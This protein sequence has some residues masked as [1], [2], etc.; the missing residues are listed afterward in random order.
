M[1][2]RYSSSRRLTILSFLCVTLL[3]T[4][5]L[6]AE[7]ATSTPMS[8]KAAAE[9]ANIMKLY[10]QRKFGSAAFRC[11]RAIPAA[12]NR[13]D[14]LPVEIIK[15]CAQANLKLGD[16][17]A[18]V[19]SYRQAVQRWRKAGRLDVTLYDDEAFSR[20]LETGLPGSA[21]GARR[22]D[23]RQ[24][25]PARDSFPPKRRVTRIRRQ[26]PKARKVAPPK[27]EWPEGEKGP[28]AG[29]V[30]GVGVSGG[31]D[32][33]L[34]V[35]LAWMHAERV[36]VEIATGIFFRTLDTRIKVYGLKEMLTPF[37]GVGMLTPF[38]PRAKNPSGGQRVLPRFDLDIPAYGNLYAVG[39]M[40][41]VDVGLSLAVW[42][43]EIS[44][45]A[46]FYTSFNQDDPNR[47]LFFPQFGAQVMFYFP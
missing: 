36:S 42:K 4:S 23:K 29:R 3:A 41:H 35:A 32:G 26:K 24:L 34:T 46:S 39:Q 20:R 18:R 9:V 16:K 14:D 30:I 2:V 19:K 38:G 31:W 22:L 8:K 12:K 5:A 11:D 15:I 33:V 27:P 21:A 7:P 6:A 40:F 37:I 28:R 44:G 17:L 45:G 13:G 47:L 1:S 43:M 10:E 25:K